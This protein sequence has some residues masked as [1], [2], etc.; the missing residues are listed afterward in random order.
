M[1][2]QELEWINKHFEVIH[3]EFQERGS[4]YVFFFVEIFGDFGVKSE[5]LCVECKTVLEGSSRLQPSM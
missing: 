2:T 1:I 5:D 4:Y 3:T